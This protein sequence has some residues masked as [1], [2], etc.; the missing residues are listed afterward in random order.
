LSDD[1]MS[2]PL[3]VVDVF[4]PRLLFE[5]VFAVPNQSIVPDNRRHTSSRPIIRKVG[6]RV[7]LDFLT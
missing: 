2:R 7:K 1:G 4:A 6:S 3:N 5:L